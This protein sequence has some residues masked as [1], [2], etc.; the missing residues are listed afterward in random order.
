[1]QTWSRRQTEHFCDKFVIKYINCGKLIV[2]TNKIE[3]ERLE[4]LNARTIENNLNLEFLGTGQI[5]QFE[6]NINGSNALF[7]KETSIVNYVEICIKLKKLI[8]GM[9]ATFEFGE[10]CVAIDEKKCLC[11]HSHLKVYLSGR[12][13]VPSATRGKWIAVGGTCAT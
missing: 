12:S 10:D 8:A 13:Q 6:P 2:S 5:R 3:D 11:L 4:I 1:M 7:C 9:G